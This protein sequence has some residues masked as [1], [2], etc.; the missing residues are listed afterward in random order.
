MLPVYICYKNNGVVSLTCQWRNNLRAAGPQ[1]QE[2]AQ[3]KIHPVP[4][5]T[6]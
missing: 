4:V 3:I 1:T 5:K 6:L 2:T